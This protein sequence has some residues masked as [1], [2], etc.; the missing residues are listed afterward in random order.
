MKE[1]KY[2]PV[3]FYITCYAAT[4]SF[5]IAISRTPNDNG[6]S[7]IFMLFGLIAPSITAIVTVMTSG[8]DALKR[9]FRQ[10]ITGFYRIKPFNVLLAILLFAA[11][12]AISILFSTLF[13]GSMRQFSFTEDFSFSVGGTSALL[14]ILL[15]SVIEETAWRGYGEDAIGSYF[16]WC[17]ESVIFGCIW[18]AWHLPLFWIEGTYH[19]GLTQLGIVYVLNFLVSVIPM[20][21]LTTW[22]YVKN[23]RS[24]LAC[25]ILHLFVNTMQEKIAMTPET[26]CLETIVLTGAAVLIVMTNK[27]LFFER[28]H[29]GNLLN[30]KTGGPDVHLRNYRNMAI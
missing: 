19:Y 24:M 9:D 25:I 22:V 30:Y 1:Y 27:E 16:P 5:W 12:V 20:N 23:N 26:K 11:V 4:W 2:R 21:F 14:T 13:G 29:I 18:A 3:R 15:A 10:K 6:I 7:T 17:T 8:S 28:D